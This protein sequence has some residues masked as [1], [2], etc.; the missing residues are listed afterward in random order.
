MR[1]SSGLGSESIVF[2]HFDWFRCG[3]SQLEDLDVPFYIQDLI[4]LVTKLRNCLLKTRSNPLKLPFGNKNYIQVGHLAVLINK[5]TKDKHQL[6]NS[7][8]DPTDRQN[9]GS[10]VRMCDQKVIDLLKR[11]V[12]DSTATIKYLE[13]IRNLIDAFSNAQIPPLERIG[14]IWH[15]TF[16][17]RIWR[18]FVSSQPSITLKDNFLTLNCYACIEINAHNLVLV[19]LYLKEH[20]LSSYFLPFLLSSQ[21]CEG[22]FRLIRS[23]SSTYST[24]ANCSVK[25]I[26]ARINKIQLQRDISFRSKFEYPRSKNPEHGNGK[27]YNLPSVE[28]I[29]ETIEKSKKNAFEDA[30]GI[31]LTR[32][33]SMKNIDFSCQLPP[34]KPKASKE[35]YVSG[36][37]QQTEIQFCLPENIALKNYNTKFDGEDISPTS[38]FVEIK[39][40]YK[41][42]VLKKT[43]LCWLLQADCVK[44]SSDRLQRVRAATQN[45]KQPKKKNK[46]TKKKNTKTIKKHFR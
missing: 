8:L 41:R 43:S 28:Q 23:F 29:I 46:F 35:F 36:D 11:H 42:H 34:I 5:F 13:I 3:I 37:A 22:F 16:L 32:Q 33:R 12:P 39:A 45:S 10:A 38:P 19:V 21:P 24:V 26:V 7:V 30:F 1:K 20:N 14:K 4:H 17:I 31:G 27:K 40:G 6:T 15:V 44:L 2:K 9:Y 25:E 18:Q